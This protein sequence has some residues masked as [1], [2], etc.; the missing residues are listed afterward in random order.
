MRAD[1]VEEYLTAGQAERRYGVVLGPGLSIDT[2]A[3]EA[4]RK[5]LRAARRPVPIEAANE[6][7]F[8]GTRRRIV[9]PAGIAGKA[10][11]ADG[12]L[13]EITTGRGAP[14]RAWAQLADE[15]TSVLAGASSLAIVR[16]SPGDTV[17][18]APARSTPEL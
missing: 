14:L 2:A 17:E 7:M 18:I 6:E 4:K 8:D 12:A 15:G 16:A 3:T 9:V 11:I 13:V 10:G 1:V 5:A